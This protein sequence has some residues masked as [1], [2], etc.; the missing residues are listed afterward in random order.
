MDLDG[1]VVG[2]RLAV[3][4]LLPAAVDH[5]QDDVEGA[6]RSARIECT[7]VHRDQ[8]AVRVQPSVQLVDNGARSPRYQRGAKHG[9]RMGIRLALG[10]RTDRR[11]PV[12]RGDEDVV[13]LAHPEE[14]SVD[15]DGLHG[16][17]ITGHDAQAMTADGEVRHRAAAAG[18]LREHRKPRDR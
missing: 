7:L 16:E 10:S 12:T 18:G 9:E 15:V 3:D 1:Q 6:V 2:I 14:V 5:L 13:V 8:A 17:A 11:G 4:H